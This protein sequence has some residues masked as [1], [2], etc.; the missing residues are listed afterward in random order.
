VE[1]TGINP[2]I[3]LRDTTDYRTMLRIG[4]ESHPYIPGVILSALARTFIRREA[5]NKKIVKDIGRD[6]NQTEYLRNIAA[7]SLII[8]GAADK[9]EHVDNAEFLQQRIPNSRKIVIEGIGHVPM[10]EAPKQVADAFN[11]FFAGVAQ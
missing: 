8:W 9:V 6:L 7:L 5:I 11:T 1:K 2:M 10:V 3:E 4:M